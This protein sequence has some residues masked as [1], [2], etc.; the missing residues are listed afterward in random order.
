MN[1]KWL[2]SQPSGAASCVSKE[3]V[4]WVQLSYNFHEFNDNE[5]RGEEKN[6]KKAS[7]IKKSILSWKGAG[8]ALSAVLN[9]LLVFR[10]GTIGRLYYFLERD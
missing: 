4:D 3:V 6:K 5:S 1:S 7:Q 2:E 8:S 10:G 9:L